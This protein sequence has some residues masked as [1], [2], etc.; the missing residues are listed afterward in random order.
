MRRGMILALLLAL[1]ALP[2][3]AVDVLQQEREILGV[4]ALQQQLPETAREAMQRYSP[5]VYQDLGTALLDLIRWAGS[6]SVGALRTAVQTAAML[7]S[8]VM[9]CRLVQQA[10]TDDRL[11]LYALTGALALT[12]IFAAGMKSMSAL[13]VQTLD[14]MQTYAKLLLPVISGAAAACGAVTGAGALYMGSSLFFGFLTA[15]SQSLI[16][17]LVYAYLGLAAIECGLQDGRLA[18]MRQL[19]GWCVTALLKGVMYVFTAY[20]SL[21]GLLS[22]SSDEAAVN[23]AK[24]T[25]SAAIPVVGSIVSDASEAVVSSAKLLRASAGTFGFLAVLAI[26]L[27]P[28]LKITVCYLVMK[29]TTAIAGLFGAKPH[30]ALLGA[31]TTAMGYLLGLVGCASVMLLFSLCCFLKV[32]GGG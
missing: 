13:A 19:L 3:Q 4:D 18:A 31:Q 11:H 14:E 23:A 1:L 28:F 15:A 20:L 10:H 5:G 21:T 2:V 25:L 12:L 6:L 7:L 27:A 22:G 24:S 17:P 8:A 9:L 30:T 26:V 32:A 29:L 16:L